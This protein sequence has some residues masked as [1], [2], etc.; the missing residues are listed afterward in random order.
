M[1]I[2]GKMFSGKEESLTDFQ[3]QVIDCACGSETLDVLGHIDISLESK[4]IEDLNA[5]S[6]DAADIA[7][8]LEKKFSI[9]IPSEVS[10]EWVSIQDVCN[11]VDS[12][13]K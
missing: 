5:D 8:S 6:L 1:G 7:M 10:E 3:K 13:Q 11:T 4:L 2:L 9:E 12:L